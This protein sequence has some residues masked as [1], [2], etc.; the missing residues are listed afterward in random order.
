[1]TSPSRPENTYPI[2]NPNTKFP[3]LYFADLDMEEG[4]SR[5]DPIP[6]R[7]LPSVR[8]TRTTHH[9]AA[10]SERA[11]CHRTERGFCHSFG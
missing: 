5:P 4:T 6:K 9:A 2:P 11:G 10:A 8:P 1:M 7:T 3:A